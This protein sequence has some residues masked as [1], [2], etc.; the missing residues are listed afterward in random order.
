MSLIWNNS[1]TGWNAPNPWFPDQ[2]RDDTGRF[3]ISGC[4]F[5]EGKCIASNLVLINTWM[6]RFESLVPGSSPG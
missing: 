2:V 5:G 1:I 3:L 6:E 4:A